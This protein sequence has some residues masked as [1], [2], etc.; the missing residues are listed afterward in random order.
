LEIPNLLN[1]PEEEEW[2]NPNAPPFTYDISEGLRWLEE[3]TYSQE[4][5]DRIQAEMLEKIER[6][7]PRNQD[8]LMRLDT[9][10]LIRTE[11][12]YNWCLANRIP[13]KVITYPAA[14]QVLKEDDAKK[15]REKKI[16]QKKK[17]A[18]KAKK[19]NR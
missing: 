11:K 17:M 19:R 3:K 15:K 14:L 6:A 7:D 16:R 9:K 2:V 1:Q 10:S 12:E 18:K 8:Y 13:L 4:E 5:I